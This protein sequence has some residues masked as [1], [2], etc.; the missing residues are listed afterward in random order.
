MDIL[1]RYLG[2]DLIFAVPKN[3]YSFTDY[4][5]CVCVWGG[6]MLEAIHMYEVVVKFKSF[7]IFRTTFTMIKRVTDGMP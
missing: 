2:T 4:F 6:V 7:F 1:T 3:N 5:V